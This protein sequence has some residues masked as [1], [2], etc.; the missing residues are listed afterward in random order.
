VAVGLGPHQRLLLNSHYLN[1]SSE[2]VTI[3]VA[4]NFVA[5]CKRTV[6][7]HTRSFQLGTLNTG[8]RS[9]RRANYSEP[10]VNLYDPPL[11]H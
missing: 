6:L 3:D 10:T 8:R 4:V 1:G 5:A 7:H 2:P 11:N 9:W